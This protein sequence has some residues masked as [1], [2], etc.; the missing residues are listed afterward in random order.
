MDEKRRKERNMLVLVWLS[1]KLKN[2]FYCPFVS[3]TK[4][5]NPGHHMSRRTFIN[6]KQ[7]N[8]Q[9]DRQINKQTKW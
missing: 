4:S 8:R 9:T 2:D 1:F 5:E 6:N 3:V 7:T